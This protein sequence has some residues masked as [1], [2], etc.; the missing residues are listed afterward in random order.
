MRNETR[1]QFNAY[2]Q[3]QAQLNGVPSAVEQFDIN[4]SV[5]Q[6]LESKM[7]ESSAFLSRV[8]VIGV[9]QQ[10]GQKVG[11]GVSGPIA[12]RTDVASNDREPTNMADLTGDD[13]ECK[14]TEFDSSISWTQ[15]DAWAKFPD[16]QRRLRN[17]VLSWQA[18]D[19]IMIGFNRSE[20]HTSELQ[21]RGHLVC[22]LLLEKKK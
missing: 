17:Q 3:R 1:Q 21:S 16:F 4:P 13:Y 2:L 7:Q 5:Q 10:Q 12:S 14:S 11:L 19:R 18:L 8:N 9:D 6:T 22:R 20:E 15:L